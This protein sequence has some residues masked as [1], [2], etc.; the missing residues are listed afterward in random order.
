MELYNEMDSGRSGGRT[1]ANPLE[2]L[3]IEDSQDDA[4]MVVRGMRH[5]GIDFH[6]QRVDTASQMKAA[7]DKQP[8]NLIIS[9]YDLPKFSGPASLQ[10]VKER[11]LDLPFIVV[12]GKIGEETAIS[13][14][15]AGAHDYI[16]K[17]N[18]SRLVPAVQRELREAKERQ[19]RRRAGVEPPGGR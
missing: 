18:L 9:D 4:D 5:A 11:G 16:M 13:F 3:I 7:L 19:E 10:M 17:N 6:D 12:S 14:L 8:W 1:A 2:I 15:K